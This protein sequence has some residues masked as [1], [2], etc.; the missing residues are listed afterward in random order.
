MR[1]TR[2]VHFR[3]SGDRTRAPQYFAAA[4]TIL[5][6]L[7]KED[8]QRQGLS[9]AHRL[10]RLPDG[11]TIRCIVT[12]PRLPPIV[13]I[14]V[15]PL[16]QPGL[17][18][19][20]NMA[21]DFI[22]TGSGFTQQTGLYKSRLAVYVDEIAAVRPAQSYGVGHLTGANR[23]TTPA[24]IRNRQLHELQVAT[25]P[26]TLPLVRTETYTIPTGG[27]SRDYQR[28]VYAAG[29]VPF[30]PAQFSTGAIPIDVVANEGFVY[31]LYGV[32]VNTGTAFEMTPYVDILNGDG[33][34][35]RTIQLSGTFNPVLGGGSAYR[36]R[37]SI[38]AHSAGC[39]ILLRPSP[40][41]PATELRK[42]K[43]DGTLEWQ[44]TTLPP[45]VTDPFRIMAGPIGVYLV[46]SIANNQP[47]I[48][49]LR[50]V[51]GIWQS[52]N[53]VT[54]FDNPAPGGFVEVSPSVGPDFVYVSGANV[55]FGSPVG[56]AD[57]RIH[58]LTPQLTATVTIAEQ[59]DIVAASKGEIGFTTGYIQPYPDV[60]DMIVP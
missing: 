23:L 1:Y 5:G 15:P 14:N 21:L 45:G 3:L 47:R 33:S 16:P 8:I 55:P 28:E 49:R 39:Y 26:G 34:V 42:Y 24:Y 9:H 54:L 36:L 51:D 20:G 6:Y 19:F 29:A 35:L 50:A 41:I 18:A 12:D 44:T 31:V 27:G 7:F 46:D 13:E 53:T 58:V 2:E 30:Y 52:Q 25:T 11:T 59:A 32:N 4:R 57:N 48:S 40:D 17:E 43:N 10:R 22:S 56:S 37:D 60:A 38:A